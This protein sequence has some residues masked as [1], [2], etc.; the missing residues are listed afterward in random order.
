MVVGDVNS[1]LACALVTSKI[2][3]IE[4]KPQP[5]IAHVEA[6]LRSF[7]RSMPEE[8]NRILAD[9]LW[10]QL[11]VR[12]GTERAAQSEG[13]R[14][15]RGASVYGGQYHDRLLAGL[16]APGGP[17]DRVAA[18]GAAA[19]TD[20][21]RSTSPYALRP[22]TARQ[23]WTAPI[24]SSKYWEVCSPWRN[25]IPLFSLRI[26][27]PESRSSISDWRS[28]FSFGT[29]SRED[30]TRHHCLDR[31][32]GLSGLSLPDETRLPGSD[33]LGRNPR[34]RRPVSVFPVLRSGKISERPVTIEQGTNVLAGVARGGHPLGD[35]AAASPL[36]QTRWC[37]H[38]GT[39]ALPIASWRCWLPKQKRT[40]PRAMASVLD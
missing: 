12:H 3:S 32:A 6:G 8:V 30:S 22:C 20:E 21:A 27:A 28:I 9:H 19:G 34:R 7:D 18:P 2:G 14:N 15:S 11:P 24:I 25:R 5:R 39:A 17:I 37:R 31:C 23:T 29:K 16:S 10:T 35:R 26:P 4:G 38:C 1:T 36:C 13:G 40:Q 33:G